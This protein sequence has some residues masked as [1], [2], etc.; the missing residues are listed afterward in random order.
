MDL[1]D[2]PCQADCVSGG[3]G[4]ICCSTYCAAT[5]CRPTDPK[6]PGCSEDMGVCLADENC[7]Y[8]NKCVEGLCRRVKKEKRAV[9]FWSKGSHGW[10]RMMVY[11][12]CFSYVICCLGIYISVVM[13]RLGGLHYDCSVVRTS[14]QVNNFIFPLLMDFN[15]ITHYLLTLRL[16]N[17]PCENCSLHLYPTFVATTTFV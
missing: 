9:L 4:P 2:W 16:S 11:H 10:E 7:C 17:T 8:N 1:L 6:W 13:E 14:S 5:K 3:G 12:S 15:A